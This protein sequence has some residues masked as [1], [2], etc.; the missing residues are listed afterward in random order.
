MFVRELKSNFKSAL[1]W[2]LVLVGLFGVVMMAYPYIIDTDQMGM[3]NE[4][5]NMFPKELLVAFNM[6]IA[7]IDTAFGWLKSEGLVMILLILGCYSSMLGANILLKEES[8]KTIE[9]LASLPVSRTR[10]VVTKILVGLIYIVSVTL[11]LG[12]VNFIAL[13]SAGSFDYLQ[14]I[15]LSISP[16]L[17]SLCIY[18]ISMFISTFTHKT[19]HMI[20]IALGITFVSYLFNVFSTISSSV[21]FLKY[22]SVFT[23]ADIRGIIINVSLNPVLLAIT[24]VVCGIFAA[25]TCV[26]YN[27]KELV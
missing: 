14:F 3:M 27:K 7:M 16:L 2:C 4:M 5:M 18:F 17:P 9:Y 11:I 26:R 24:L 15:L 1:I 20:G 10:I 8:D 23:L 22:I 6:D 12:I 13:I 19:K 21:E 25:L